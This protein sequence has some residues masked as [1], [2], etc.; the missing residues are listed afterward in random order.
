MKKTKSTD[1]ALI[2][3]QSAVNTI[4]LLRQHL[5]E[6]QDSEEYVHRIRV[7]IKHLRAWLRLLRLKTDG[8]DWKNIDQQLHQQAQQLGS[9]RDSQAISKTF[10]ILRGYAKTKRERAAIDYVQE[11]PGLL[12]T[13]STIN[14]Q[15]FKHELLEELN[16]FEREFVFFKSISILINGLNHTYTKT[17]KIGEK[18]Y[19]K[20]GTYNDIHNLRKWIKVMG[21]Q[22]AYTSKIF[23]VK[24]SLKR[25]ISKLGNLLGKA[26]D[27]II[28]K[29]KLKLL[30]KNENIEIAYSLIEKN[31]ALILGNSKHNFK[32]IFNSSFEKIIGET[33]L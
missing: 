1:K 8:R 7:D 28:I 20:Q 12:P 22:L 33:N 16:I 15:K 5:I 4:S 17:K 3:Q 31:I 29:D 2:A 23:S 18:T 19:S 32:R 6:Q 13:A 26:H 27:L 30:E 24:T 14:W 9:L 25:D 11:Q 10:K 21:Y